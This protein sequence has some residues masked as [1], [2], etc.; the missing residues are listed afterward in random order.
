MEGM[1]IVHPS[2]TDTDGEA[3][4]ASRMVRFCQEDNGVVDCEEHG[5]TENPYTHACWHIERVF[6]DLGAKASH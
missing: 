2:I 1:W 4:G 3:N 5:R 6:E